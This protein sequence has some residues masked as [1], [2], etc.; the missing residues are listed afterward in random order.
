MIQIN[1]VIFSRVESQ[2]SPK[3]ESGFQVALSSKN[4]SVEDVSAIEKRV[5][6]FNYDMN[7]ETIRYQF[8]WT[9]TKQAAIVKSTPVK[10]HTEII[11]RYGRDGAFIAHAILLSENDFSSI[12]NDPFSVFEGADKLFAS[13]PEQLRSYVK[14]T[15][16]PKSL[17]L[18]LRKN[19][20]VHNHF[21]T[22]EWGLLFDIGSNASEKFTKQNRSLFLKSAH[23]EERKNFLSAIIFLV[24][25]KD[26]IHCTFDTHVET[27]EPMS[28]D[29]W[30]IGGSSTNTSDYVI[31]DLSQIKFKILHQGIERKK[32]LYA[33]W[34]TNQ[35]QQIRNPLMLFEKIHSGQ[36]LTLALTSG[37]QVSKLDADSEIIQTFWETNKKELDL[38][39]KEAIDVHPDLQDL[40][41]FLPYIKKHFSDHFLIK[42]IAQGSISSKNLALCLFS[43]LIE[44]NPKT[45]KW[46]NI[47]KFGIT[48]NHLGIQLLAS[49]RLHRARAPITNRLSKVLAVRKK[50]LQELSQSSNSG[51]I[52]QSLLGHIPI[53]WLIEKETVKLII[54]LFDYQSLLSLSDDEFASL[55]IAII[56]NHGETVISK[57][58]IKRASRL[59][60]TKK[61]NHM[62]KV[63][64]KN[65]L[66]SPEFKKALRNLAI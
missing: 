60:Q 29:Y 3:N 49:S 59:T 33:N 40:K 2:Y 12:Q 16:P 37:E 20:I 55:I 26:R 53:N 58:F 34:L 54:P 11:D 32:T 52:I 43:W 22:T 63:V 13:T 17:D 44:R 18:N 46:K 23:S 56:E 38:R 61:V 48:S 65:K 62:V 51:S 5:K 6:C 15:L 41:T 30:A 35:I 1:H 39:L 14:K 50:A 31:T 47:L 4:I 36:V 19:V 7:M 45:S 24:E 8:F 10:G 64:Q 42:T 57:S 21:S 9:P 66:V 28:G 27:C 25:S